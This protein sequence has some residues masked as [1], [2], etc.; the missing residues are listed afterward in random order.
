MELS[1]I[2]KVRTCVRC[3]HAI[4]DSAA[5]S[6][7]GELFA[8]KRSSVNLV[9]TEWEEGSRRIRLASTSS[10][11]DEVMKREEWW[12]PVYEIE[13]LGVE[14][15]PSWVLAKDNE[16]YTLCQTYPRKVRYGVSARVGRSRV[17]LT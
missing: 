12:Q 10:A 13:R 6:T 5:G 8:D 9:R 3:Y 15:S 14:H 7:T 1:D 16:D 4:Q 2:G 17:A 11:D